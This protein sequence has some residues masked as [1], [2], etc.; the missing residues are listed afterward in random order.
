[1][2]AYLRAENENTGAVLKPVPSGIPGR[3]RPSLAADVTVTGPT[4][5]PI[6][7]RRG[8]ALK[9]ATLPSPAASPVSFMLSCVMAACTS[10]GAPSGSSPRRRPSPHARPGTG[11]QFQAGRPESYRA[12]NKDFNVGFTTEN[13]RAPGTHATASMSAAVTASVSRRFVGWV[14]AKCCLAAVAGPLDRWR[15]HPSNPLLRRRA[16][17]ALDEREY[18]A[19]RTSRDRSHSHWRAVNETDFTFRGGNRM[20]T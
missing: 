5:G 12:R 13:P 2:L 7:D 8:R 10:P 6:A 20:A 17:L 4:D 19:D 11:D 16:S 1:M 14:S 9:L 18:K 3:Q 15:P